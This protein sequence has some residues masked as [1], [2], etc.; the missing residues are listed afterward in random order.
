MPCWCRWL[1]RS[2]WPS[3]PAFHR[4][5]CGRR[6]LPV[7]LQPLPPRPR[8]RPQCVFGVL[9]ALIVA[10]LVAIAANNGP[11][12][13]LGFKNQDLVQFGYLVVILIFV[14]SALIGRNLGAGEV[15]RATAGW[16]GIF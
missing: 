11:A 9:M 16:L 12:E 8:C 13:S 5:A 6:S 1:S 7:F 3:S 2:S 14:G 15:V 10:M 4:S